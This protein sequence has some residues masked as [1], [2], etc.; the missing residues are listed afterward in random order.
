MPPSKAIKDATNIRPGSSSAE[1]LPFYHFSVTHPAPT[2]R[3]KWVRNCGISEIRMNVVVVQEVNAPKGVK[4]I[5][6]VLLTSLPV[7]TFE[8]AWQVVEDYENRWLVE[9]YHKVIK[10]A[11]S[12]ELHA[13]QTAERLEPL[14]GLISVIGTRLFQLK[15]IG[16]SQPE[17]RA[18]THVPSSWLKCIKLARP[19]C[20]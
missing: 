7:N 11:C 16:R 10:S 3:S 4:P 13:L 19:N 17:A 6:W 12:V 14:I 8:D 15:L 18:A 20:R 9:E 5:Q 2:H 1:L